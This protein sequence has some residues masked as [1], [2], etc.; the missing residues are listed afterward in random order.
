MKVLLTPMMICNIKQKNQNLFIDFYFQT[1]SGQ[2]INKMTI[3]EEDGA[4]EAGPSGVKLI[5][6][7]YKNGMYNNSASSGW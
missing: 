5:A 1:I 7:R 6:A 4:N 3:V 2:N